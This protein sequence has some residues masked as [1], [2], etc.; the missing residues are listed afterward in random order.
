MITELAKKLP[1]FQG[2]NSRCRCF[3]HILNLIVK[4]ILSQFEGRKG[5]QK[6]VADED[7]ESEGLLVEFT[8]GDENSSDPESDDDDDDEGAAE[9]GEEVEDPEDDSDGEEVLD[10]E[11]E[12]IDVGHLD[13]GVQPVGSMLSKASLNLLT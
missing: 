7:F 12:A 4:S 3:A 2:E 13:V 11:D 8:E 5:K 9:S 10:R 6:F 1:W